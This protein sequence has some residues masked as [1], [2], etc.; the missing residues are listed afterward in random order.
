MFAAGPGTITAVVTLAAVH[1]PDGLP[2]TAI[3]AALIGS[4]VTFAALLLAIKLGS[5][6]GE[7]TQEIVTRFMGLIVDADGGYVISIEAV[8]AAGKP[9][10]SYANPSPLPFYTAVATGDDASSNCSLSCAPAVTTA[11]PKR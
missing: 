2:V 4:G 3:V 7:G 6:L 9:D 10:A 1:T 8:D 11:R 5:R